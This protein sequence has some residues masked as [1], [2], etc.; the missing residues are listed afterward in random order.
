ME[1][2]PRFEGRDIETVKEH[3]EKPPEPQIRI[4]FDLARH[5]LKNKTEREELSSDGMTDAAKVGEEGR[6]SDEIESRVEKDEE[7]EIYGS[8]R[9]RTIQ[10]SLL[11]MLGDKFKEADFKNTDPQELVEWFTN[12]GEIKVTQTELLDFKSGEGDYH[13]ELYEAFGKGKLLSWLIDESDRRAIETDQDPDKVDTFSTQAGNVAAFLWAV[14]SSKAEDLSQSDKE[15]E[16]FVFATSH[17]SILES[18]IYKAIKMNNG[19]EKAD[20]FVKDLDG[21][22]FR[23]NQGLEV[24]FIASKYELDSWVLVVSYNGEEFTLW[25]DELGQIMQEGEDIREALRQRQEAKE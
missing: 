22:G 10:S 8:G 9:E 13:D 15:K 6:F 4:T 5:S 2:F 25:P 1:K 16:D 19:L 12:S 18:F 24:E 21:R 11:R 17:Q 23:E 14:G 7:L 3:R 20:Q